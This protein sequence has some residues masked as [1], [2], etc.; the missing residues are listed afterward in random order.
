MSDYP[1]PPGTPPNEPSEPSSAPPPPP[2]PP[3]GAGYP[4]PPPGQGQPQGQG[5]PPPGYGQPP[6]Q[7]QGYAYPPPPPGYGYPV[8]WAYQPPVPDN[9]QAVAGFVFSLVAVGLLV[10]SF[11]LSTIVSLGC[12]IAGILL[13]RGGKRKVDSGQTP[14]H[15]GL[16]QAGF[17]IGWVGLG[18]SIL[19]TAGWI[20]A[21]VLSA[22]GESFNLDPDQT[23]EIVALT[24]W[25]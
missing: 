9:G 6:P 18:L 24:V 3:P 13:S 10:I 20:L 22:G 7:Q 14:K 15:R 5:Q 21:I 1:P 23:R 16:A 4:P 17:I 19:A 12:A 2:P 25:D 11:G 8:P